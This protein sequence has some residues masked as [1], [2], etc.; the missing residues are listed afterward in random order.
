MAD[1]ERRLAHIGQFGMANLY[2]SC[3]I[4]PELRMAVQYLG[5]KRYYSYRSNSGA[6]EGGK[7]ECS[8][9]DVLISEHAYRYVLEHLIGAGQMRTA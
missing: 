7:V 4:A 6:V 1:H 3:R 8:M 5:R 9:L 2:E